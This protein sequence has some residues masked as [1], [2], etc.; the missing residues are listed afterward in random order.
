MGV[1]LDQ[2][3]NERIPAKY[4]RRPLLGNPIDLGFGKLSPNR[5]Q[6]R[7]CVDNVAYSAQLYEKD[8]HVKLMLPKKP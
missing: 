5:R 7:K 2:L 8:L 1:H 6:S 4:L 3:S